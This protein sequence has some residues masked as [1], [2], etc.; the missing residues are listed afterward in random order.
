MECRQEG[1]TQCGRTVSKDYNNARPLEHRCPVLVL[2]LSRLTSLS[3]YVKFEPQK[4][5]GGF[6]MMPK[7]NYQALH[8]A[9]SRL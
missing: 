5:V 6:P 7:R 8:R 3:T 4:D 2:A 9:T 1:Q